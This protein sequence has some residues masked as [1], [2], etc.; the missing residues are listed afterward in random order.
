MRAMRQDGVWVLLDAPPEFADVKAASL[1][2]LLERVGDLAAETEI[3]FPTAALR[4]RAR[5]WVGLDNEASTLGRERD[6]MT[7]ELFT[8]L[9]NAG[10]SVWDIG[11]AVG[12]TQQTV[13]RVLNQ[14][15]V[16]M[17]RSGPESNRGEN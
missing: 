9:Y 1:K 6:E 16:Q 13:A 11:A 2:K 4:R 12:R 8:D 17:R 10:W 5:V 14:A 15:G 3:E 7:A